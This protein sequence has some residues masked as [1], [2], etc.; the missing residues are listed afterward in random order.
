MAH[1]RVSE[2][3]RT[4]LMLAFLGWALLGGLAAGGAL[5]V[6]PPAQLAWAQ[7]SAPRAEPSPP[8][9]RRYASDVLVRERNLSANLMSPFCP[10]RTMINCS[11]DQARSYRESFKEYLANGVSEAEIREQFV[12]R[13]G[14][15][16]RSTPKGLLAWSIPAVILAAGA[17]ALVFVLR[18][19]RA[20]AQG[21]GAQGAAA[22]TVPAASLR[23]IEAELE[24]DLKTRGL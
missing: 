14:D 18:R 2:A 10:G 21:A 22:G 8:D 17:C 24:R 9:D 19:F 3:P 5:A 11:S 4:I 13:F 16:A 20:G 6:L 12:M 15:I 7:E 23:E 1:P